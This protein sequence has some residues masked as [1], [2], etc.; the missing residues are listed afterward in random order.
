MHIVLFVRDHS[1]A[2]EF[3]KLLFYNQ[4]T[5]YFFV[6]ELTYAPAEKGPELYIYV[7]DTR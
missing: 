6:Y 3:H 5:L 2:T 7:T 1:S 4:T